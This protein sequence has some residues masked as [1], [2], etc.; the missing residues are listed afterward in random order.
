MKYI[1]NIKYDIKRNRTVSSLNTAHMCTADI[2]QLRKLKLGQA[3]LLS[4]IGNIKTQLSIFFLLTYLH[5][6]T[7]FLLVYMDSENYAT[8]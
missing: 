3:V 2:H 8:T 7:P 6:L 5:H 4:V 1:A